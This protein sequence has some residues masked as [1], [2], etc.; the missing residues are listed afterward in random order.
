M[1]YSTDQ[2]KSKRFPRAI[3]VH[4]ASCPRLNIFLAAGTTRA[5]R[6]RMRTHAGDWQLIF[7]RGRA[8]ERAIVELELG[9]NRKPKNMQSKMLVEAELVEQIDEYLYSS[10]G[11]GDFGG[12]V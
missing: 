1:T 2:Q 10:H 8:G 11:R 3:C 4:P 9:I 12:L 5:T 6:A 7:G